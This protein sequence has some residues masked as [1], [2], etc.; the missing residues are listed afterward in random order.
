MSGNQMLSQDIIN[1][2][3][4]SQPTAGQ[5]VFIAVVCTNQRQEGNLK[6]AITNV[7]YT[8]AFL[9]LTDL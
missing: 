2:Q 3:L 4:E 9:S 8:P 5:D 1:C 7:L 6:P